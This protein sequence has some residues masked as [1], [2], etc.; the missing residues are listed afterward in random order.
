[1]PPAGPPA[2][3]VVAPLSRARTGLDEG[4]SAAADSVVAVERALA[5]V[6][7]LADLPGGA[8]LTEVA[9]QL[10]VNKAI[11]SR[12]LTSLDR[13]GYVYRHEQTGQYCLTYKVSNLGL[14]QLARTNLLDQSSVIL[15]TLADATGELARLAVVERDR[16][17]WV[18]ASVGQ[19]RGLRIDPDYGLGI[20]LHKH[21]AGKAWIASLPFEEALPLMLAQGVAPATR[22]TITAI[23]AIRADLEETRRRGY[24]RNFEESELGVGAIAAPVLVRQIDGTERCVGSVSLAAPISRMSSADLEACSPLVIGTAQRLAAIWPVSDLPR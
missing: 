2:A 21:A 22:N 20:S 12:L 16:I 9:R 4:T 19:K 5:I 13:A 23:D 1:M 15:R 6:E 17:T 24:A 3:D 11:A 7:L 14:R 10:G 18:A 8:S